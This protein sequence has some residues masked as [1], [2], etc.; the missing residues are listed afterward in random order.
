MGARARTIRESL[1]TLSELERRYRNRPPELRL[2]ALRLLKE[3]PE[4]TF[5]EVADLVGRSLRTLQRWW[6]TYRE[7]GLEELLHIR[8]AGGK[9]PVRI[10]EAGLKELQKE[11]EEDGFADLKEIQCFLAERFGV[12]YSLSGIWYLVRVELGAKPKTGRPRS[13][14][15][16]PQA[17]EAFKK[18]G[19]HRWRIWRSGRRTR[20]ASV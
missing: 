17:V 18:G 19:Y 6:R 4:W 11:L 12:H 14:K 9:R 1:E 13:A 15:Q 2:K 8:K 3:H 5:Q 7:E 20:P 10:G 16:D